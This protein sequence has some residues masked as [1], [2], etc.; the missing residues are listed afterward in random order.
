[1]N[2]KANRSNVWYLLPMQVVRDRNLTTT[3][4]NVLSVL[5]YLSKAFGNKFFRER[6]KLIEDLKDSD[7]ELSSKQIT[8]CLVKLQHFNYITYKAGYH[9]NT[10]NKGSASEFCITYNVDN[11]QETLNNVPP[12]TNTNTKPNTKTN[13][14]TK[15]TN[16]KGTLHHTY[17]ISDFSTLNKLLMDGDEIQVFNYLADHNTQGNI[18][19]VKRWWNNEPERLVELE[20]FCGRCA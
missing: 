6:N 4:K 16:N 17:G 5:L 13:N 18:E 14:K 3:E 20:R 10:T 8:R 15:C 7:V 2:K 1:M 12:N 19:Y 9:N 11:Q